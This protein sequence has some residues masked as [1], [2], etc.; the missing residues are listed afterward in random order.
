MASR[1]YAVVRM[2]EDAVAEYAGAPYAVA[3]ESCT[4]ALLLCCLWHKVGDVYLP[5]KTYVSVPQSV[6]H[7]GGKVHFEDREWAGVYQLKPYSIWDG[8]KRFRPG[9]YEGGEHCLSFHVNKILNIGRG[10]M[11]LTADAEATAW[12]RK[13]RYE[14]RA[15]VSYAKERVEL[16][17]YNAYMTPEQAARGLMLLDA[18]PPN[19]PDQT[20]NYPDLR[21]HPLFADTAHAQA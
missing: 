11:I 13:M 16:C 5:A 3:V 7:A 10:G 8:A 19:P 6:M 17:G 21:L 18:L 2:F 14:G 12:F 15:G 9:M 1:A 20:E 4:A